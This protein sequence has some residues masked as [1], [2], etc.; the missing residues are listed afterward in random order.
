MMDTLWTLLPLRRAFHVRVQDRPPVELQPESE[1]VLCRLKLSADTIQKIPNRKKIDD[2]TSNL[3]SLRLLCHA[4]PLSCF[5]SAFS[6]GLVVIAYYCINV[7]KP[8]KH[9]S[10]VNLLHSWIQTGGQNRLSSFTE[11]TQQ[12]ALFLI[13]MFLFCFI[14][15]PRPTLI[16]ALWDLTVWLQDV[17]V[18]Y[19]K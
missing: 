19:Q 8:L 5:S 6:Y 16:I 14:L 12:V 3:K 7:T 2:V 17:V 15:F 10:C 18:E 13:L 11:A 9:H 1:N 4:V